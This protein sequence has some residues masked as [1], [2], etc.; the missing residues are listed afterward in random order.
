MSRSTPSLLTLVQTYFQTHLRAVRGA[1]EHTVRAY[2][3]TLRL[4]FQFA[5]EH[6]HRPVAILGLDDLRPE[7]IL[8]FLDHL[9]TVRGSAPAARNCR[10]A[11]IHRFFQH[12]LRHDLTRA[13]QYRRVLAIPA[14]RPGPSSDLHG[15]RRDTRANRPAGSSDGQRHPGPGPAPVPVQHWCQGQ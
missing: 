5:A 6:T 7:V 1:S 11:A 12:L 10:L 13:E 8:A 4:F 15:A 14:K 3:D 2:R 9:E